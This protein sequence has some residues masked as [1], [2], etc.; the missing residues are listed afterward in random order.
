MFP[1]YLS[2]LL[3]PQTITSS[4]LLGKMTKSRYLEQSFR[5]TEGMENEENDEMLNIPDCLPTKRYK[6]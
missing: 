3:Y 5:M 6:Y 2:L 1:I 4:Q